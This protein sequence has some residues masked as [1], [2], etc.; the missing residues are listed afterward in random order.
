M[1][2]SPA[3]AHWARRAPA[4]SEGRLQPCE[5]P[6][7]RHRPDPG[8]AGTES[9]GIWQVHAERDLTK[10][11]AN[12]RESSAVLRHPA[13]RAVRDRP[14]AEPQLAVSF[15]LPPAGPRVGLADPGQ[16]FANH[17]A[18]RRSVRWGK[19]EPPTGYGNRARSS[20]TSSENE[21]AS[22]PRRITER[23]GPQLRLDADFRPTT[24]I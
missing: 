10:P 18:R 14:T 21:A 19:A 16:D 7:Q 24:P 3:L 2:R 11:S 12:R 20:C 17:C 13:G 6:S 9:G 1:S 8:E 5:L 4:T 15:F 22:A 23:N